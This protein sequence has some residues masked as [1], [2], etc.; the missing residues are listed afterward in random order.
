MH[1]ASPNAWLLHSCGS[2]QLPQ[3]EALSLE[4]KHI[5]D[6]DLVSIASLENLK[7]LT[8]K[9]SQPI[10][11]TPIMP[12]QHKGLKDLSLCFEGFATKDDGAHFLRYFPS[13]ETLNLQGN[14]AKV[15][16][17]APALEPLKDLKHLRLHNIQLRGL[18]VERHI[19]QAQGIQLEYGQGLQPL[20]LHSRL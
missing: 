9:V 19:L 1:V 18:D 5:S 20:H 17:Y 10:I 16:F 13:L 15:N 12:M 8:L 2:K 7:S 4:R 11:V 3:L 6:L 14:K